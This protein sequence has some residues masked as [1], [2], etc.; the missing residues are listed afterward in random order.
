MRVNTYTCPRGHQTVTR[1]LDE[2]TTP[3]SILCAEGGHGC[4]QGAWSAF[5][6]VP[7]GLS[8]TH[9]FYRPTERQLR[10]AEKRVPGTRDHVERGGLLLRRIGASQ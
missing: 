6:K 3:M 7:D 1:D 5:Y 10:R 4:M 9:E 8:P 2:G